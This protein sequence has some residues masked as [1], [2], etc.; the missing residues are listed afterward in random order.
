M[1][2]VAR[3]QS[4]ADAATGRVDIHW[5]AVA[6]ALGCTSFTVNFGVPWEGMHPLLELRVEVIDAMPLGERAVEA[7]SMLMASAGSAQK[8]SAAAGAAGLPAPPG[9][10][11][12]PGAQSRGAQERLMSAAADEA[13]DEAEAAAAVAG[14][15][16]AKAAAVELQTAA[17]E[18]R[19]AMA[20][21]AADATDDDDVTEAGVTGVSS[22]AADGLPPAVL[23]AAPVVVDGSS[24]LPVHTT[25]R[26]GDGANTL[27]A[28]EGAG[29]D[30]GDD[31]GDRSIEAWLRS[32]RLHKYVGVVL[33]QGYEEVSTTSSPCTFVTMI[34]A[35]A[36]PSPSGCPPPTHTHSHSPSLLLLFSLCRAPCA[37]LEPSAYL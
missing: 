22:S 4:A 9:K 30:A 21:E 37:M 34:V 15:A 13:A 33:E 8:G 6:R 16:A 31:D 17:A 14:L 32:H 1:L 27:S 26:R 11:R 28:H 18:V 29:A 7:S 24:G 10:P 20:A 36:R 5:K 19:A 35:I 23:L 25:T 12:H 3:S 2:A